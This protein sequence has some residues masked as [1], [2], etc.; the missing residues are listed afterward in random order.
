MW[1]SLN[2]VPLRW[3]HFQLE[4]LNGCLWGL[5][6]HH[7]DIGS[8]A[9]WFQDWKDC[10][11]SFSSSCAHFNLLLNHQQTCSTKR[12][13]QIKTQESRSSFQGQCSL[14]GGRD[15]YLL[16]QVGGVKEPLTPCLLPQVHFKGPPTMLGSNSF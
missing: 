6:T 5:D 1:A 15:I 12:T 16:F 4:I 14:Q 11:L 13:H 9:L 10:H 2:A 3:D 7:L 8:W